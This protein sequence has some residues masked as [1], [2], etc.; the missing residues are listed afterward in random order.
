MS[1]SLIY[2]PPQKKCNLQ[3]PAFVLVKSVG[4]K[5]QKTFTR[6]LELKLLETLEG[7]YFKAVTPVY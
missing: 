4:I 5:P 3:G 2:T 6:P 1:G 7:K